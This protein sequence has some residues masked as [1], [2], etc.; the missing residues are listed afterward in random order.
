MPQVQ[1]SQNHLY[2]LEPGEPENC[3]TCAT[4]AMETSKT[5]PFYEATPTKPYRGNTSEQDTSKTVPYYDHLPVAIDPVVGWLA[6]VS[7]PNQGED[8]RLVVGRNSIGRGDDLQV[9]LSSDNAVSRDVQGI[10]SFDPRSKAFM[11]IP[12]SGRGLIYLNGEQ[13]F[14]ATP[15]KAHDKIEAGKSELLFIPLVTDKFSW[16]D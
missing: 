9:N 7:G 14:T 16:P 10:I 15:I 6:C 12:G 13:V 4:M 8:W 3:P 5:M 11:L 2:F 1:C